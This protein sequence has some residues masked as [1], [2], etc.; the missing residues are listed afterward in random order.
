MFGAPLIGSQELQQDR[1]DPSSTTK[2]HAASIFGGDG[3]F[4]DPVNPVL[5]PNQQLR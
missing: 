1:C 5:A 4:L 2:A 3:Y